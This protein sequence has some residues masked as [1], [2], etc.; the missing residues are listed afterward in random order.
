[1]LWLQKSREEGGSE[2]SP[3]MTRSKSHGNF[4][5]QQTESPSKVEELQPDTPVKSFSSRA[6]S[7]SA[8]LTIQEQVR[9]CTSLCPLFSEYHRI[10]WQADLL[11]G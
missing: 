9:S 7:D 4:S 2:K 8:N 11:A 6:S 5:Q 1:M 3:G 10:C